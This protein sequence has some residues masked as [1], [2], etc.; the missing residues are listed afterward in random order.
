M[1]PDKK[2]DQQEQF[3][4]WQRKQKELEKHQDEERKQRPGTAEAGE[5]AGRTMETTP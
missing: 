1:T 3:E 5:K 2:T 4:Q